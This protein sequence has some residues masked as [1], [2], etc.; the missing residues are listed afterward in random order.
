MP[1]YTRLGLVI[2]QSVKLPCNTS[3]TADIIWTYDTDGRYLHNVYS[4][5]LIDSDKPR[6][7]VKSTADSF[8]SLVLF[9]AELNDSGLYNCY[10]RKGVRKIGYELDIAG[11][12]YYF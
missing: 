3:L 4:N 12:R 5:G 6:L 10:D 8:Y 2:G 7:A 11:M 9:G 1:K